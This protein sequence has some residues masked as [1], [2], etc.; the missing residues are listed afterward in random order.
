MK[1]MILKSCIQQ[2]IATVLLVSL[3]ACNQPQTTA[4][5]SPAKTSNNL[6]ALLLVKKDNLKN[7]FRAEIY[8]IALLLMN[9]Y[10]RSI[11]TAMG[12]KKRSSSAQATKVPALRSMSTK[13]NNS[14]GSFKVQAMGVKDSPLIVLEAVLSQVH[15]S[16]F[17]AGGFGSSV[18]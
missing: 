16:D 12:C 3:A 9:Y 6:V 1:F 17:I 5:K 8:P 2:A 11:S 4:P 18:Q 10:K 7:E 15:P 13:T 14:I